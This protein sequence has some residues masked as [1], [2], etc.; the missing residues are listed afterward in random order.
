MGNLAIMNH[1]AYVFHSQTISAIR[2]VP[3]PSQVDMAALFIANRKGSCLNLFNW[4]VAVSFVKVFRDSTRA[5]LVS[6]SILTAAF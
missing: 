1:K 4:I 6:F 5:E 2:L 3:R